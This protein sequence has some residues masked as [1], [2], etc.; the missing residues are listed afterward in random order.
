MTDFFHRSCK[1]WEEFARI[2][3]PRNPREE[4]GNRKISS[5]LNS[6]N[7]SK[8]EAE[9]TRKRDRPQTHTK[10][11]SRSTFPG[12]YG[13]KLSRDGSSNPN[14]HNSPT[15]PQHDHH[16]SNS[17]LF[18]IQSLKLLFSIPWNPHLFLLRKPNA[19]DFLGGDPHRIHHASTEAGWKSQRNKSGDLDENQMAEYLQAPF[20]SNQPPPRLSNQFKD[21]YGKGKPE[22][23]AAR[24]GTQGGS[25]LIP[26]T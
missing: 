7:Q 4:T 17:S 20:S 26:T 12:S 14:E 13:D 18:L 15:R 22:T 2:C 16:P 11:L 5:L 10:P 21:L 24:F 3:G 9:A 6:I 1:V 8:E 25:P 23:A 19:S